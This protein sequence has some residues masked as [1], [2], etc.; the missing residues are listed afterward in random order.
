M[1]YIQDM[2]QLIGS[3]LLMTV[4]CGVII[5]RENQ[6]LLQHRKDHDVWGI[7]GGVMEPGE[8][9]EAAA[10]REVFEETGLTVNQISLFGLYSGNEGYASYENGDQVF[11]VQVIFPA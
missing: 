8:T 1:N 3:N 9:F 7:P 11:S 5:E 4:G 10:Q 6:I 2:R